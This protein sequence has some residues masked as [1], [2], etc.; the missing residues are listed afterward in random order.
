MNSAEFRFWLE[1]HAAAFGLGVALLLVTAI[2][3]PLLYLTLP[4]GAGTPVEGVVVAIGTRETD[5]G[6]YPRATVRLADTTISVALPR[7]TDCLV[8][9]KISL[10]R[11]PGAIGSR[12]T[13]SKC[14]VR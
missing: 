13:A 5:T 4:R 14:T 2:V 8:G 11:S 6:S 9:S 1:D 10:H 12:Y 3:A 7:A